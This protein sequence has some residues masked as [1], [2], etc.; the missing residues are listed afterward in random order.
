VLVP[1]Y[2]DDVEHIHQLGQFVQNMQNVKK[3]EIQ[4]YHK[5]G[6]HKYDALGWEYQ[7]EDVEQNTP[8]Q[9]QVAKD[10]L[11]SYGKEVIVN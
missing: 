4:P 5:L 2:S 9:L 8:Q 3:I 11:S 10:I 1:G 7:L 6:K